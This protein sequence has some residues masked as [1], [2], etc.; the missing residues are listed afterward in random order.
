VIARAFLVAPKGFEQVEAIE[1]W[2]AVE[3][4]SAADHAGPV[5]PGGGG[6]PRLPADVPAAV[7]FAKGFFDAGK[8]GAVICHSP[9]TLIDADVIRGRTITSWPSLKTDP[10]TRAPTGSMRKSPS[11]SVAATR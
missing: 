9:W 2:K 6:Q 11:I 7:D 1:P 10:A 8:L 5:L 4:A 3:D